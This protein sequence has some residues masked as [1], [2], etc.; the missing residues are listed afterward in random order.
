MK[1]I[2]KKYD[3]KIEEIDRKYLHEHSCFLD[4][5]TTGFSRE[6]NHIYMIGLARLEGTELIVTL[7]FAE[8]ANEE[9][10][11]L[12]EFINYTK[13]ITDFIT[14]NGLSFDFPFIQDR[15]RHFGYEYDFKSYNHLD[16]FKECKSLKKLLRLDN[17]KQ[18]TIEAFLEIDRDDEFN[19]GELI[20]QYIR[21]CECQDLE[22]YKNLITH[23]LEDVKGMADIL[24]IL[25]YTNISKDIDSAKLEEMSLDSDGKIVLVLSLA[26]ALPKMFRIND[27]YYYILFERDKAKIV[28]TPVSKELRYYLTDYKNYVYIENEDSI[29]PK[30]LLNAS[31]K[32]Y[33]TKA[34]KE[35]CFI[36]LNGT[37]LP[38]YDKKQFGDEKLFKHT[39]SDKQC[40]INISPH[41]EDKEYMR[42]YVINLIKH[43]IK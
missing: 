14:F 41:I 8:N 1:I 19:G 10:E 37:F 30:Q 35:N 6:Y 16:T 33:A 23:N 12:E 39:Y 17:L 5:E 11:I 36:S 28:L 3:K 4:I 27:S 38:A 42:S 15:L 18:K 13:D 29:I 26:N 7:L 43:I 20:E 31:N 32:K 40:Y 22:C 9:K 24:P 2:S 21:Y 25:R 34:T